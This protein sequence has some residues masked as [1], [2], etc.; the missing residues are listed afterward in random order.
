MSAGATDTRLGTNTDKAQ[1]RK[2]F[3]DICKE[4]QLL[5]VSAA[6]LN[7]L[8]P[9]RAVYQKKGSLFFKTTQEEASSNNQ[10][11]LLLLRQERDAMK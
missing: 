9:T 2:R 5:E 8:K 4:I 7:S 6:E 1:Q 10:A 3:Q 11:R